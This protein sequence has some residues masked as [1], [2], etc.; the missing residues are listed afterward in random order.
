MSV[1]TCDMSFIETLCL[2]AVGY[3]LFFGWM[4]LYGKI[5]KKRRQKARAKRDRT[6]QV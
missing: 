6:S 4:F 3:S 2:L 1:F 5:E